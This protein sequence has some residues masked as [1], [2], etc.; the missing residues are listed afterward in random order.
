MYYYEKL[1][2]LRTE[3]GISQKEA[4]SELGISQA[5]LSHYEKGVREYGLDFL[6]RAATY[7]GV[8]AD[9][10]LGRSESRNG[11]D[12]A[13]LEDQKEDVKFNTATVYRAALMTHERI[14]AGSSHAGEKADYL[15][16]VSIYQ[17]LFA[18]SQKGYIPKRWFSLPPKYSQIAPEI[19]TKNILLDF[20]DKET[21]AR[22]YGGPEPLSIETVVKTVE[23]AVRKYAS[24][25]SG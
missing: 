12:S 6:C 19:I 22:R 24:V 8:T 4:A 18:A 25:I 16:A 21:T 1:Y 11:F 7:Y 2:E 15:Y 20:P 17:T 23:N 10:L 5:L 3:K 9:Y 14:N 13:V